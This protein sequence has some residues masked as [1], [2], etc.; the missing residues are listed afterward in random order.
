MRKPYIK[1][2]AKRGNI[3]VWLIDGKYVRENLNHEFTNFGQHYIFKFIPQNEFWIDREHKKGEAKFFIDHM[4]IEHRLMAE[5]KSGS[6]AM[7]AGDKV[8]RRER[9]NSEL[10]KEIYKEKE[11]KKD[12]IERVHK[13]LLKEYGPKINVWIVSGE[14]VRDFFYTDFTEGGHNRVYAFIPE[15]EI[16]LDDDLGL[17]ERKFV[18][19]HELHE[20]G[21]MPDNKQINIKNRG[22]IVNENYTKT[23][24][25]AHQSASRLEYF[26]R[27]HPEKLEEKLKTEMD[28]I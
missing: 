27:H 10:A 28:K 13:E 22:V 7:S 3:N 2:I 8:E 23:Y 15:N 14:L 4:L 9:R 20:R 21:L 26:C 19:L 18:L 17:Q 6:D 25:S 5:G 11:D 12:L 1:K 16:W 24:N